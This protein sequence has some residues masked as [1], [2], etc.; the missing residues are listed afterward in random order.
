MMEVFFYNSPLVGRCDTYYTYFRIFNLTPR[1]VR[2][3]LARWPL[4]VQNRYLIR[5]TKSLS[6]RAIAQLVE[7]WIVKLFFFFASSSVLLSRVFFFPLS[8]AMIS[9]VIRDSN[10]LFFP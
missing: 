7:Q 10:F 2:S 3:F 8:H 4:L 9:H 1:L 5:D 6:C